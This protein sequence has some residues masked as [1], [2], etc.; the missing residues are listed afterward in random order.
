M[1]ITD[2]MAITQTSL[3]TAALQL[4]LTNLLSTAK[5]L[6]IRSTAMRDTTVIMDT[7]GSRM[8]LSCNSPPARINH[9]GEVTQCMML[10]LDH[11][12]ERETML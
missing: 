9:N 7:G 3:T 12:Q 5:I 1:E 8:V 6:A 10:Q 2:K 4:L 11:P